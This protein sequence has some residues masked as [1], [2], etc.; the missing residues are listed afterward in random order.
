VDEKG[1]PGGRPAFAG[2]FAAEPISQS[3]AYGREF[4]SVVLRM[5]RAARVRA[6]ALPGCVGQTGKAK[7]RAT[8]RAGGRRSRRRR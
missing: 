6:F 7:V 1:S 3:E 2:E 5:R 4:V 8:G